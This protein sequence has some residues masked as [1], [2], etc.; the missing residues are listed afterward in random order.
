MIG[1]S[2]KNYFRRE[3]VTQKLVNDA[4]SINHDSEYE[5]EIPSIQVHVENEDENISIPTADYESTIGKKEGQNMALNVKAMAKMFSERSIQNRPQPPNVICQESA[6]W[7]TSKMV[8]TQA[9]KCSD[10]PSDNMSAGRHITARKMGL[11]GEKKKKK[12]RRSVKHSNKNLYAESDSESCEPEEFNGQSG[13]WTLQPNKAKKDKYIKITMADFKSLLSGGNGIKNGSSIHDIAMEMRRIQSTESDF[14]DTETMNSRL[15]YSSGNSAEVLLPGQNRTSSLHL[16]NPTRVGIL[17]RFLPFMNTEES[18]SSDSGQTI[19]THLCEMLG[20][21]RPNYHNERRKSLQPELLRNY[22]EC[23]SSLHSYT[24][25][26]RGTAR[27]RQ[28]LH[29]AHPYQHPDVK[30]SKPP[31][32]GV[33]FEDDHYYDACYEDEFDSNPFLNHHSMNPRKPPM[34]SLPRMSA[35]PDNVWNTPINMPMNREPQMK[36]RFSQPS[37][38]VQQVPVPMIVNPQQAM[39]PSIPGMPLTIPNVTA[40]LPQ[41]Q[42]TEDSILQQLQDALSGSLD[43]KPT[44]PSQSE[45]PKETK[46]EDNSLGNYHN[47]I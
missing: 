38:I 35:Q 41:N 37:Q 46:K 25:T 42:P 26:L 5:R 34:S 43:S 40:N 27:P 10:G 23:H 33:T 30:L 8:T 18:Q 36:M 45:D 17:K 20:A 6:K 9:S 19:E 3:S 44:N 21:P 12:R 22:P 1:Q 29:W 11:H 28:C 14:T 47:S 2:F 32:C 7:N 39:N 16:V 24:D 4:E 15:S 31:R 13:N